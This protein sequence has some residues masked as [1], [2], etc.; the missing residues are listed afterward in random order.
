MIEINVTTTIFASW[1]LKFCIFCFTVAGLKAPLVQVLLHVVEVSFGEDW[2]AGVR[3]WTL[4]V[5]AAH[6]MPIC[7]SW[8]DGTVYGAFI[9]GRAVLPILVQII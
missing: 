4:R 9:R 7:I 5:Q 8:V 6:V 1:I 3:V 2:R